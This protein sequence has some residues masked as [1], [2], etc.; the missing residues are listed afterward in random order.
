MK[1]DCNLVLSGG[2]TRGY[3]HIGVIQ[4]LLEN[5]ISIHAISGSSC[6]AIIGAFICDGFHPSEVE[7]I[8]VKEEP[9]IGLNYSRFWHNLLSFDNYARVLKQNLRS[10]TFDTLSKPLY[11]NLTDL[12]TGNQTLISEGNL[13][14]VLIATAA[15]PVLLPACFINGVP[16]ADGGLSNNL[17]VEPFLNST[18]KIIGVHVNPIPDFNPSA[19]VVHGLDRSMHLLMRSTILKNINSCDVFIEPKALK[20]H[21]LFESKKTKDLITI[22]YDYVM[23]EAD[24]SPLKSIQ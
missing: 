22:G 20:T 19:S 9:E 1:S 21:H 23:H 17:P 16:Y 13:P 8:L 6:G 5:E 2:G 15:I 10:K 11:V 24:L 3:S 18:G 7:E 12:N 14:E 4:A